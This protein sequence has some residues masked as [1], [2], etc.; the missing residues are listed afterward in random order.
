MSSVKVICGNCGNAH[1]IPAVWNCPNCTSK[2]FEVQP[3]SA[4]QTKV[5]I[6][7]NSPCEYCT[8]NGYQCDTCKGYDEFTGRKLTAV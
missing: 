2:I 6:C 4:Q 8:R 5:V 1:E 3:N 7:D